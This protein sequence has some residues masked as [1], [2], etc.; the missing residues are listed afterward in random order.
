MKW[1][2]SA[3]FGVSGITV[4]TA[5]VRATQVGDVNHSD[6]VWLFV[7]GVIETSIAVTV[8]CLPSFKALIQPP[9]RS[10]TYYVFA[11]NVRASSTRRKKTSDPSLHPLEQ[12]RTW[13]RAA[14]GA[15]GG[16]DD[17]DDDGVD[18][19]YPGRIPTFAPD[20]KTGTMTSI[21]RSESLEDI[22]SPGSKARM[23]ANGG[24]GIRVQTE[25]SLDDGRG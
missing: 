11:S 14:G 24:M 17:D 22:L 2:L 19:M 20:T 4:I 12:S 9:T 25:F 15:E 23:A 10:R 1:G 13:Y 18:N 16:D 7:W 5:I 3:V 21:H 6:L 8:G